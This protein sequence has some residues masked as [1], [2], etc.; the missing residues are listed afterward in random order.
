M[1][2]SKIN[3][4]YLEE[5]RKLYGMY[6]RE[7]R[8]SK[9]LTQAEVGAMMDIDQATV[10]KIEKGRWNFGIDTMTTFAA[11]LGF[12]IVFTQKERS[13][14]PEFIVNKKPE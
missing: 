12:S 2:R 13:D 9:G 7:L 11:H 4:E 14:Q 8:Q 6:F 3:R 5:V 10:N 1:D